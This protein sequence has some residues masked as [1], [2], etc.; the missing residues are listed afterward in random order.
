MKFH[1]VNFLLFPAA[2]KI[3]I[4]QGIKSAVNGTVSQDFVVQNSIE[5]ENKP[6]VAKYELIINPMKSKEDTK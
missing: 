6:D 2:G 1:K 3:G 4:L 5:F